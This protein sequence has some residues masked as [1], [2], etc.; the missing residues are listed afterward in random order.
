MVE[1]VVSSTKNVPEAFEGDDRVHLDATLRTFDRKTLKASLT[2]LTGNVDDALWDVPE[3]SAPLKAL[4]ANGNDND[5]RQL[6]MY[7]YVVPSE[8][9]EGCGDGLTFESGNIPA[10]RDRLVV[11]YSDYTKCR[12]IPWKGSDASVTTTLGNSVELHLIRKR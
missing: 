6:S 9:N 7:Y 11:F 1:F 4:V 5:H 3:I 12:T 8:W 10:K 2:L